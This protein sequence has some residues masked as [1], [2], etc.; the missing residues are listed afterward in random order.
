MY[1]WQYCDCV[2]LAAATAVLLY[3]HVYVYKPAPSWL[4]TL[5]S[6]AYSRVGEYQFVGGQIGKQVCLALH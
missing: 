5:C 3:A 1:L 6:A 4:V 2:S